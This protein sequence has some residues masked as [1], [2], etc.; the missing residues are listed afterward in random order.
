[1]KTELIKEKGSE[2]TIEVVL[3]FRQTSQAGV[4]MAGGECTSAE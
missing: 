3:R 1:M 2:S 4:T